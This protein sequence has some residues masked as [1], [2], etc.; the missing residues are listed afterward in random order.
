MGLR[1]PCAS[2]PVLMRLRERC[3]GPAMCD[4]VHSIASTMIQDSQLFEDSKS[5]LSRFVLVIGDEGLTSFG[6][7]K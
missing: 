5:T 7:E 6:H 4:T 3:P 1:S 2:Q